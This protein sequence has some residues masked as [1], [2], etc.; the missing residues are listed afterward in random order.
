M[1]GFSIR[2]QYHPQILSTHLLD[3]RPA[4]NPPVLLNRLLYGVLNHPLNPL[5]LDHCSVRAQAR[6]LKVLCELHGLGSARRPETIERTTRMTSARPQRVGAESTE[7][8]D[9]QRAPHGRKRA[10]PFLGCSAIVTPG[11]HRGYS[12]SDS[13]FSSSSMPSCWTAVSS[14]LATR[15][16]ASARARTFTCSIGG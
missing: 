3:W 4:S 5:K 6:R 11:A 13:R 16:I 7:R 12:E 10:W 15:V 1:Y 8:E 2:Q 14:T 9:W